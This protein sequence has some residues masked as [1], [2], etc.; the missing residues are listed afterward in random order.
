MTSPISFRNVVRYVRDLDASTKMYEALGFKFLN[1]RGDMSV[2]Q[3]DSGLQLL[4]HEYVLY[5]SKL[6]TLKKNCRW[7]DPRQTTY[8]DCSLGFTINNSVEEA[9]KV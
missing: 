3:N 6:Q 9:R 5:R 1:K 2:L 4:L 8:L 7:S